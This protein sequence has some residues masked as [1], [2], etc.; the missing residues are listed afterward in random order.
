MPKV[1]V[2]VQVSDYPSSDDVTLTL[3]LQRDCLEPDAFTP[4]DRAEF[5][6]M[7]MFLHTDA[8]I[9]RRIARD[10]ELVAK[11]LTSA[12]LKALAEKDLINGYPKERG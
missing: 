1:T 10:R 8:R 7:T 11:Q 9:V 4:I 6:E 3:P 2:H 5:G 12:I